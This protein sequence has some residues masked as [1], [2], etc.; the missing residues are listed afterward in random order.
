VKFRLLLIATLA[1]TISL[2]TC[3]SAEA[4]CLR[5]LGVG[6]GDGYHSVL[7]SYEGHPIRGG[8]PQAE[9]TPYHVSAANETLRRLPPA[10]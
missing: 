3:L 7:G 8:F 1:A 6:W 2:A 4:G 5:W 9:V 10:Y